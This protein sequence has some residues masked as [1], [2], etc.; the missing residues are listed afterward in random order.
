MNR[1]H[2][3][4]LIFLGIQLFA[5]FGALLLVNDAAGNTKAFVAY[6]T[7]EPV[8]ITEAHYA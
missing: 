5:G 3:Q 6:T 1:L 8:L 7:D 2:E 4:R